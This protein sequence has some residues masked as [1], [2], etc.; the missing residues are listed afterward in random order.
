MPSRAAVYGVG[1]ATGIAVGLVI[2]GR[3][4]VLPGR[5]RLERLLG[6]SPPAPAAPTHIVLPEPDL[7]PAVPPEAGL[8][9]AEPGPV[10]SVSPVAPA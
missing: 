7:G 2:A 8:P 6:V 5:A 10:V 9:V 1:A 4:G 3:L